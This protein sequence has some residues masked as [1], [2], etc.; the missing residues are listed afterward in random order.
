MVPSNATTTG[1]C[2]KEESKIILSWKEDFNNEDDENEITFR[3]I[4]NDNYN[5]S[6]LNFVSVNIYIQ[7]TLNLI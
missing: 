4:Y 7:G 2:D 5:A 1:I 3:Y 6:F